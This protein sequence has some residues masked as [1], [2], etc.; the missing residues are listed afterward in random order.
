[1]A[2]YYKKITALNLFFLIG[3]LFL[4]NC[5]R[6]KHI[7]SSLN[8]VKNEK[9]EGVWI[10]LDSSENVIKSCNY[11]NDLLDGSSIDYNKH[12]IIIR[13]SNYKKGN[14]NGFVILYDDYGRIIGKSKYKNGS[15]IYSKSYNF[16]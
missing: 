4:F 1:M 10:V 2:K 5:I 16:Y 7:G 3:V 12:R 15:V 14:L 8:Q 6:S 13:K 9:K 11:K